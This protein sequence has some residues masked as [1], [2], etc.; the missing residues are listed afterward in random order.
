MKQVYGKWQDQKMCIGKQ[1]HSCNELSITGWCCMTVWE[2]HFPLFFQPQPHT[3]AHVQRERERESEKT[4]LLLPPLSLSQFFLC[5]ETWYI[6]FCCVI[7]S[8]MCDLAGIV[9][10][11]AAV[12][13]WYRDHVQCAGTWAAVL[14]LWTVKGK[15]SQ[16]RPG[17]NL[18]VSH[19]G[20][21]W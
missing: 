17:R 12:G 10:L 3:D 14:S 9:T 18:T 2:R 8:P 5:A 13:D 1:N 7:F 16:C 20:R 6:F 15:E 4:F 19:K 11:S 21:D